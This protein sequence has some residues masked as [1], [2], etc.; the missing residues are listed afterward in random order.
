KIAEKMFG[1]NYRDEDRKLLHVTVNGYLDDYMT[2]REITI[3]NNIPPPI[4]F[5]PQLPKMMFSRSS[6]LPKFA[7]SRAFEVPENL[8]DLAFWPILDIS[9]LIYLEKLSATELTKMFIERIK[10]YDPVLKC[11]VKLTDT[12]ALEQANQVDDD[13]RKNKHRGILHGIPYGVKDLFAHPDYTTTWGATPYQHQHIDEKATVVQRLEEKGA[14]L[15]A[16]TTMGALAWGDVWFGGKTKSP[17]NTEEGSSGSSAGSAAATAAGMVAFSIGTET[18]GSIVSPSVKCGTTALRPTF[19]RVSRHGGMALAW[20]M[21]KVGPICKTIEDCAIVF[22][23]IRGVDGL[24][25]TVVEMPFNYSFNEDIYAIKVGYLATEF[26][27]EEEHK[28]FYDRAL[29]QM[30]VLGIELKQVELPDINEE[31]LAFILSAEAATAFDE[32]TLSGKLDDL[33]RQTDDAWPNVFRQA[34]LIPAVEYIKANRIRYLMMQQMEDIF[35][36]VDVY[37]APPTG[38]NPLITNLT[39]HPAVVV[40]IGFKENNMPVSITFIGNLYNEA[41]TLRIAKAY[42]DSTDFHNKMPVGI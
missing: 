14:I 37:L 7:Q 28:E 35:R 12:L 2:S 13:M 42:Q 24:D 9:N 38:R 16:K 31:R 3:P 11:V 36:E 21:D 33:V 17:W 18:W 32:L 41:Q 15:V 6:F 22:D 39:G 27:K 1:L 29:N 25:A 34:R 23:V 5:N 8:E 19:G 20:S 10:R 40:P 26:D 30:K 4:Y